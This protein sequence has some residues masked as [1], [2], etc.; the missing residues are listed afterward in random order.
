MFELRKLVVKLLRETA[1]KLDC[2]NSELSS[3][4]ALAIVKTLTH[5]PLSKEQACRYLGLSRSKFD[6]LV[7]DCRIPKGRKRVGLKELQWWKD[8]LDECKEYLKKK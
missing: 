3:D 4:Q 6:A 8:E 7:K 5:E 1:D 2:G